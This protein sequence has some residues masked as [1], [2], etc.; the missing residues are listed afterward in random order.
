MTRPLVSIVTPSYNQAEYLE[1]TIR[2]VLEQDYEP[3]EYVVVD[4][5]STDGSADVI[6]RYA[7]RLAW[8]VT[9]PDRG[10]AHAI[11]KGFARSQGELMGFLNSDDA[12]VPGA[13]TRLVATLESQPEALVAFGDARF[14]DD[15]NGSTWVASPGRWGVQAM[16]A[17]AGGT[18]IQPSSLWRRRAWELAG[19]FDES[20]DFWFDVL[21]FLKVSC[22]GSAEYIPEPLAVYRI[23]SGSK[24]ANATSLPQSEETLRLADEFARGDVPELLRPHLRAARAGLLRRAAWGFYSSGELGRARAALVRSLPLKLTMSR[25]TARLLARSLTPPAVVRLKRR[26]QSR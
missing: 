18:I 11:N 5:G 7:S 21:F 25:T 26:L 15:R 12:L 24:T 8:W 19:P 1:E 6:R 23:H 16:A 2:S 20:Y 4:G 13:V 22:F 10:Q 14:V 3:I 17:R 9:E